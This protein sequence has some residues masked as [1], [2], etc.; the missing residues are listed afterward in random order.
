MPSVKGNHIAYV[1]VLKLLEV[2]DGFRSEVLK[3]KRRRY[4]V[5]RLVEHIW[6]LKH[7]ACDPHVIKGHRASSGRKHKE[8]R[9][10]N[11]LQRNPQRG[12]FLTD[13]PRKERAH[14]QKAQNKTL[15]GP[16]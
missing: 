14:Q 3:N 6:H 12:T 8:N 7:I 11:A 10:H 16:A 1:K 5:D 15:V 13:C 2:I 9:K 4:S